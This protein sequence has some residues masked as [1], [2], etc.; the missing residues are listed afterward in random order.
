VRTVA[1]RSLGLLGAALAELR[2]I[3]GDPFAATFLLVGTLVYA[4]LIPLPFVRQ[5]PREIPIVVVDR[6]ATSTSRQLARMIDAAEQVRVNRV[7]ASDAE[8]QRLLTDESARGMV[9]VAEGFERGVQ[10]GERSVIGVFADAR[11]FLL[12]NQVATGVSQA[13][14]TLSA[15]IELRR[16]Q[17]AGHT[18]AAARRARDPIPLQARVLY[19]PVSGYGHANLPAVLILVLQQTLLIG[20]G[21]SVAARRRAG[22]A[23]PSTVAPLI[24]RVHAYVALY[25]GHVAVVW[26]VVYRVYDMPTAGS[27][28]LGMLFLVPFLVATAALGLALARL[29]RE[30]TAAVEALLF[31]S[32]PVL[33]LSGASF[34]AEAMPRWLR[35]LAQLLPSTHAIPGAVR[36]VECGASLAEV[37]GE[38]LALWGLA[39]G[40][41]A[42]ARVVSPSTAAE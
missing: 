28:A 4:F 23:L 37:R 6:D 17:A 2:A 32:L 3:V 5:L 13:T 40:Y 29:F 30:R 20:I 18:G 33:F 11:W 42:V 16:L 27:R 36:V 22:V 25:L 35:A 1:I 9:V 19:N 10:R 41:L 34:P 38:W 15:G 14:A 12:Y 31:T 24:G 39:V 8:A 26:F 21:V 7:V